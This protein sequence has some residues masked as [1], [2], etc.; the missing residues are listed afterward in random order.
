[1]T[2][3]SHIEETMQQDI[4]DTLAGRYCH[5]IE[6]DSLSWSGKIIDKVSQD[7]YL[8]QIFDALFGTPSVQKIY[9]VQDM[10][11]WL[12]YSD[13][14]EFEHSDNY[15][16]A[17]GKRTPIAQRQECLQDYI[18]VQRFDEIVSSPKKE[19]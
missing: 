12:F 16:V 9:S 18:R 10:T 13:L 7:H 2:L 1:M 5:C 11:N 4:Q 15:G 6:N 14:D 8:V 19:S 17:S 3:D